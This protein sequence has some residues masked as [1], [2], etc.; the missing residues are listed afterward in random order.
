L[1][2]VKTAVELF[3]PVTA[4]YSVNHIDQSIAIQVS[5]IFESTLE[6]TKNSGL[7]L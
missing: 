5:R 6:I 1:P 3:S 7:A 2:L 4:R